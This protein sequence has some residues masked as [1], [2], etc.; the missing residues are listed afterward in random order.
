[1]LPKYLL[2]K[3][4]NKN[5]F[6]NKIMILIIFTFIKNSYGLSVINLYQ[7]PFLNLNKFQIIDAREKAKNK[8]KLLSIIEENTLQKI[9]Q[10]NSGRKTITRYQQFYNGIPIIGYQVTIIENKD[11]NEHASLVTGH[12]LDDIQLN[13]RPDITPEKALEIAKSAYLNPSDINNINTQL[14]IRNFNKDTVLLTYL[15]SFKTISDQQKP[16]WPVFII[17]AHSGKIL[18]QWNNIKSFAGDG[19]GGNE[20]TQ[21]Y[22]YGRNGLPILNVHEIKP[23]FWGSTCIM[24]NKKVKVVNLKSSWDWNNNKLKAHSYQCNDPNQDP[25]NGGFSPINDAYYFGNAVVDMYKDWYHL[26]VLS[27]KRGNPIPL[28]MRIHF[29][30][31]YAGAFW[32]GKSASFGD[33]GA[34][35]YPMVSLDIIAH[36]ASH[37]FTEQ[38]SGLE[39]HDQSG[40]LNESFSDMASVSA[41]AY[42]LENEPDLYRKLYANTNHITWTIGETITKPLSITPALRFINSPSKDG[43]SADCLDKALAKSVGEQCQ[44]S[45]SDVTKFAKNFLESPE[46]RQKYITHH[47]SGVFNKAFYLISEK[48][49]I[50][51]AFQIMLIANKDHWTA[52][53][54]F[55]TA[56]CDI[57]Y[58][59]EDQM[60]DRNQFKIIFDKVGIDTAD[61]EI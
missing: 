37:G 29:G 30:Q 50:K 44:L 8:R 4:K 49:G 57:L 41:S 52:K 19:P 61:C 17:D 59:V 9:S 1:M 39:Y 25:S 40:A 38:H 35:F 53:T 14:Q 21:Q 43:F 23:F 20:K 24:D 56:A 10:M 46:K 42:L 33:G 48:V 12:L 6:K 51:K 27:D 45:Y 16:E 34:F 26:N 22:W 36:E 55:K 28:I 7:K 18:K 13:T 47:G 11:I 60:L 54:D 32:D 5:F 15:I 31:N 2:D 58:V 3:M